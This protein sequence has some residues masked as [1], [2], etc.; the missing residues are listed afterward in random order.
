M[1]HGET[2]PLDDFESIRQLRK[3]AGMNPRLRESGRMRGARRLSK[4]GRSLLR[5][6]LTQT[7]LPLVRKGHLFGEE[8]HRR[9]A[10]GAPGSK[11]M[12]AIAN[13]YLAMLFS[14][15]RN[16]SA[17]ERERVHQSR[18]DYLSKAA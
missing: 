9:K 6:L 10:A 18:T 8:Y 3:Y 16:R 4:K 14:L 2:G 13:K 7:C 17:F 1:I 15:H 11:A 12:A 5:K